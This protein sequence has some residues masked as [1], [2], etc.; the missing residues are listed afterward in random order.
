MQINNTSTKIGGHVTLLFSIQSDNDDLNSQG[1]RG[2]GICISKGVEVE[3]TASKGN[4]RVTIISDEEN[5][6]SQLYQLVI[7][8][9]SNKYDK[10]SKYDWTFSINSDL[11]FGQGFGCSASGALSAI[12]CVL[13]L[14]KEDENI[15]QNA[16]TIAHRIERMLS[17][18]LGDVVA[19]GAGGI[20]LRLEP[21]LPFPPNNGLVLGWEEKFPILLCWVKNEEK[22]TSEYI[23]DEEWKVKISL[24]GEQCIS[25]LNQKSW[26]RYIWNDL[27]EQANI[28]CEKS[29]MLN[30]SNRKR[31]IETIE[32]VLREENIDSSW[33]VRLCM[34]GSSAIIV[35]KNLETY[36]EKELEKVL[37]KL[38]KLNFNGCITAINPKPIIT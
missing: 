16:L 35:P 15:F 26:D 24:A 21:G 18:G 10:V 25:K 8:E 23:D 37:E 6:S 11:P 5:L 31:I 36:N 12:I 28:F 34:L 1:S 29:G 17:S 27:L 4:G 2:A 20:E 22:H 7:E 19:L 9:L 38:G 3:T 14:I 33:G 30:D 32:N 13:K